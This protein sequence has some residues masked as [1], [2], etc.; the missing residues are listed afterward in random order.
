MSQSNPCKFAGTYRAN[1]SSTY[2]YVGSWFNISYVDGSGASGDYVTDTV[3]VGSSKLDNLQFGVGYRSTSAQGI[4]GVGYPV[5]EVQVGRAGKKP[6][7]NLPAKL[8]SEGKI[9]SNA[10]SLWLN[11]LSAN[12]GS[13]LFGGVDRFRRSRH[14][15]GNIRPHLRNTAL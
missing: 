13:I 2:N 4:L 9:A 8:V 15:K 14:P 7:D 1:S 3:T 10:Y 11:D 6:Y 5:N 12:T